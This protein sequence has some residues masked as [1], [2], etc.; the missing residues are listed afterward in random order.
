MFKI[1]KKGRYTPLKFSIELIRTFLISTPSFII[2]SILLSLVI[3]LWFTLI[4][5][6][7]STKQ[8]IGIIISLS[9]SYSIIASSIFYFFTFFIPLQSKRIKFHLLLVNSSTSIYHDIHDFFLSIEKACLST[10]FIKPE[11]DIEKYKLLIEILDGEKSIKYGNS[12]YVFNNPYECLNF[13]TQ[14]IESTSNKILQINDIL[15]YDSLYYLNMILNDCMELRRIQSFSRHKNMG[16]LSHTI[17]RLVLNIELFSKQI[18]KDQP[19]R[20]LHHYTNMKERENPSVDLFYKL[21]TN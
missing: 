4:W 11:N 7:D 5:T 19:Y 17:C 1:N 15:T 12:I 21:F 14:N 13:V 2:T 20:M 3:I 9:I 8:P 18:N 10:D 6:S 16:Y